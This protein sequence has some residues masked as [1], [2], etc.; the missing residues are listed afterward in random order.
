MTNKDSRPFWTFLV[1]Q[2]S[3]AF[4]TSFTSFAL[5]LLVYR[6]TGSSF[7][8]ASTVAVAFLPY[9]LFGPLAG[10]L[11]DRLD[12]KRVMITAD[13]AR[14]ALLLSLPVVASSST[15]PAVILAAFAFIETAFEMLHAAASDAVVPTLADPQDILKFNAR[16][17]V[18]DSIASVLGPVSAALLISVTSLETL[19][20]IDSATFLISAIA[21]LTIRVKLTGRKMRSSIPDDSP[22]RWSETVAGFRFIWRNRLFRSKALMDGSLNFFGANVYTQLIFIVKDHLGLPDSAFGWFEAGAALTG[23]VTATLAVRLSRRVSFTIL[24]LALPVVQGLMAVTIGSSRIWQLSLVAW[25]IYSGTLGLSFLIGV[26][27]RQ[28]YV[29]GEM[30]GRVQAA[31]RTLTWSTIPLGVLSGGLALNYVAVGP[32]IAAIGV[33]ICVIAGMFAWA[34]PLRR[35]TALRDALEPLPEDHPTV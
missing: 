8:M 22:S 21:V 10:V 15:R 17:S 1:G 32:F 14:A 29:P 4:G 33:T 18:A 7:L 35:A 25:S 3:S 12:R 27:L 19:F 24:I 6:I 13:V 23:I 31:Q 11:A 16:L 26:E 9:M 2:T 5:P 30:L 20:R 28:R 34:S